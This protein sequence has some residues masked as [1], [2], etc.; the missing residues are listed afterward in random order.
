VGLATELVRGDLYQWGPLM[1]GAML[2]CI[3]VVI[4]Y[5]LFVDKYVQGMSGALKG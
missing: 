2:G 5:F 3:P 4:L 1:A